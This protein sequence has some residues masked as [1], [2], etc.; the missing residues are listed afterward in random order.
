M[1]PKMKIISW[2]CGGGFRHKFKLMTELGFD[3]CIIQEC[4]DPTSSPSDSYKQ[5]AGTHLWTGEN[6]NKGIGIF[7]RNGFKAKIKDLSDGGNKLFLPF[8]VSNDLT[9]LAVWTKGSKQTKDSYVGQL[10]SYLNLNSQILNSKKIMI[11]G[12]FNSNAL[13]DSKR[14]T[15]NHSDV[16][17]FLNRLGIKSFYHLDR[18]EMHGEEK[19]ATFFM[20][21]NK[22]KGYH[23]DYCFA[24][25]AIIERSHS[26]ALGMSLQWLENSDHVPLFINVDL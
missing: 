1:C 21:R 17:K 22:D 15:G 3:M 12:D 13:W 14:P 18:D 2:N 8:I 11:V 10:W 4:E 20:H 5:W 23:I 6:R 19:E 9:V 25:K 7:L 16:V 24:S 26:I